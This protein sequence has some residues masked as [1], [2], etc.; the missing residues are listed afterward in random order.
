MV[1]KIQIHRD[2][3][4]DADKIPPLLARCIAARTREELHLSGIAILIEKVPYD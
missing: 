1:E 2:N 4:F 3:V